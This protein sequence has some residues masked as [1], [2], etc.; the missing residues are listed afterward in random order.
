VTS[1]GALHIVVNSAGILTSAPTVSSK[2]V[3]PENLFL[4]TL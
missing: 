3:F 2:G 1:F 4:K